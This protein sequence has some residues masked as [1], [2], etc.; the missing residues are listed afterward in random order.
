MI[1]IFDSG[2]GGLT[3]LRAVRE[4]LP[5]ADIL[6]FGDLKNAPYGEKPRAELSRLTTRGLRLLKSRGTTSIVSACNSVAA[7]LAVSLFDTLELP[8]DR[9]VEMVGST[10]RYLRHFDRPLLIA[11]TPATV[12]SGMYQDAFAM[13]GVAV[14]AR[15]IAGLAGAIERGAP[16]EELEEIIRAAFAGVDT[17]AFGGLVLACTHYPLAASAFERLLPGLPLFDPATAVAERV[18][19]QFWPR[20]AGE[21]ETR[22]LLSADS[23]VFRDFAARAVGAGALDIEVVE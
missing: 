6:Y 19:E 8:P 3:V 5:S 15:P 11:A 2:S 13:A 20:E 1:G 7:S 18:E 16:A 21:G 12:A 22:F 4:R 9:L 10:V 23:P 17:R 14:E